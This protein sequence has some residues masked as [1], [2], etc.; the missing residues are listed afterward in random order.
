LTVH[1]SILGGAD[2]RLEH[3]VLDVN[4]TL[5]DRGKPIPDA[6]EILP[7]LSQ[8]LNLHVLSA[9]TFGTAERLARAIE[10]RYQQI[11]TGSDKRIYIDSLGAS[12]CV[13]IGN[14]HNDT[15]MLRAAALG[16]AVIGPEGAHRDAL[17]AADVVATSIQS[18][19]A[20]LLEPN[21]LSATLRL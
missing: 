13:A 10:A 12:T 5:A 11:Q 6:L 16:I 18:A 9:D 19:P 17:A 7:T 21:T 2:L 3:L 4:G 8:Q 1:V 14:G 15:L 20:L